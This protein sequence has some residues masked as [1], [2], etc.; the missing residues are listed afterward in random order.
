MR[1]REFIVGLGSA[2]RIIEK[3]GISGKHELRSIRLL[4]VWVVTQLNKRLVLFTSKQQ[5]SFM[6]SIMSGMYNG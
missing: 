2:A 4:S 3:T 6:A 5:K 1:R